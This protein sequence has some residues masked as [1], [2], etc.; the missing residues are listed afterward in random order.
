[1]KL[2]AAAWE[3]ELSQPE[4]ECLLR[5]LNQS[6]R[7]G[8]HLEIGTKTGGTLRQMLKSFTP[9]DRPAFVV[10]DPMRDIPDQFAIVQQNLQ[11]QGIDLSSIDFRLLPSAE[12]YVEASVDNE[13]FDFI[14][15]DGGRRVR[16]VMEDFRWANL[17]AVGGLFCITGYHAE[18]PGVWLAASRFIKKN[19]QYR[20]VKQVDRLLVIE[21]TYKARDPEVTF[22]DT[23]YAAAWAP[24]L[25]LKDVLNRSNSDRSTRETAPRSSPK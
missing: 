4:L 10:V 23:L 11:S 20:I 18:R 14:L 21:K 13:S 19:P 3:S 5:L 12:A 6:P 15:L 7:E 9:T 16:A 2:L 1:M 8:K 17:L 22:S 24:W 25:R